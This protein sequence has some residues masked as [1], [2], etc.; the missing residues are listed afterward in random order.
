[1]IQKKERRIDIDTVYQNRC[2]DLK[3][4]KAYYM[5]HSRNQVKLKAGSRNLE[6]K[7]TTSACC[8]L[9]TY[10]FFTLLKVF[11]YVLTKLY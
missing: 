1:M 4:T 11:L 10:F 6:A 2:I 5:E 8:F 9:Y 3:S 7:S